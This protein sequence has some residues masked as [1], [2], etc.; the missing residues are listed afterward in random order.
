MSK[1]IVLAIVSIII[2]CSW[3]LQQINKKNNA[4][5]LIGTWEN[6]TQSGSIFETWT[7]ISEVELSGKSYILKEKDTIVFE[8]IQLLQEQDNLFYIPKVKNQNGDL[9]VRFSAKTISDT[10]L[11]FENQQH[12]FPQIISYTKINS[13]SLIAEISGTKNGKER[14]QTF[15][16]KRVK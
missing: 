7:K 4:E 2:F 11:M 14:K 6:K 1:K 16:M 15:P 9:P 10:E 13:D 5:W 3:T 8:T 12:D